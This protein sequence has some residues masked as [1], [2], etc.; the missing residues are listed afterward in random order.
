MKDKRFQFA[1]IFLVFALGLNVVYFWFQNTGISLYERSVVAIKK[2]DPEGML[3]LKK[4]VEERYPPAL[5]LYGNYIEDTH[6]EAA[7]V[8]YKEA[9][10]QQYPEGMFNLSRFYL[11][12]NETEK[13]L[14][15][16]VKAAD[17]QSE[18]AQILLAQLLFEGAGIEKDRMKAILLL[19]KL[20]QSG[21]AKARGFLEKYVKLL[22]PD[23]KKQLI[24]LLSR[25]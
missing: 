25:K 24:E 14:P 11:Q 16:L 18:N 13:G 4:S 23:E 17:L 5:V 20:D 1:L 21:N 2:N 7:E 8:Y 15:L 9:S 19:K 22:E 6:P 12:K 10:A 3:L